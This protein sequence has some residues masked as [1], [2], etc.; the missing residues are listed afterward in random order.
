MGERLV[1]PAL[2]VLPVLPVVAEGKRDPYGPR[3]PARLWL[4]QLVIHFTLIATDRGHQELVACRFVVKQ[5]LGKRRYPIEAGFILSDQI[6]ARELSQARAFSDRTGEQ[7]YT[8]SEWQAEDGPAW[9][10]L[11]IRNATPVMWDVS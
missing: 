10:W 3:E 5:Q 6:D 7:L 8:L 4:P 11:A 1:R 9:V 2:H